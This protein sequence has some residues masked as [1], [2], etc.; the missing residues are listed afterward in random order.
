MGSWDKS[1]VTAEIGGPTSVMGSDAGYYLY[2]NVENS[3]AYYVND[4]TRQNL[5]QGTLN[6]DLNDSTRAEAGFMYQEWRGHENGG[7]NRVTQDLIDTQTYIT[8]QPAIQYR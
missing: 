6:F 7:W 5:L 2:A 3:E 4:F 8:G 1:V